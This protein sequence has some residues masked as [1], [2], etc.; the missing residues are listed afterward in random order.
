M[1]VTLATEFRWSFPE[2]YEEEY[3]KKNTTEEDMDIVRERD[4]ALRTRARSTLTRSTSTLQEIFKSIE[5]ETEKK[6]ET[7]RFQRGNVAKP[8]TP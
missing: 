8:S 3:S 4:N 7:S 2:T 5:K 1:F 6:T